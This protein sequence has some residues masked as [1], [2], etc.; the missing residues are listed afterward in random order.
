MELLGQ[1]GSLLPPGVFELEVAG[2]WKKGNVS[3]VFTK[4]RSRSAWELESGE[5]GLRCRPG[6]GGA[7][8]GKGKSAKRYGKE[9]GDWYQGRWLSKVDV[10]RCRQIWRG[11]MM[12]VTHQWWI[13]AEGVDRS[14][15]SD[16]VCLGLCKAFDR[17]SPKILVS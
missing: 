6:D 14:R 9:G 3:A 1:R 17:V 5:C 13:G 15:G 7:S 8:P 10:C 16:V 11:S 2:K 4:G 12:R